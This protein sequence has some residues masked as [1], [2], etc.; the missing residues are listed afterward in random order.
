MDWKPE[1]EDRIRRYLLDDATPEERRQVEAQ[2]LEDDEYGELL[3]LIEDELID[4]YARGAL[5]ARES[6]LFARNYLVTPRRQQDLAVAREMTRYAAAATAGDST[7][8]EIDMTAE[9]QTIDGTVNQGRVSEAGQEHSWWQGLFVP[10]WKIAAYALLILGLGVGIWLGRSGSN[11]SELN[12]EQGLI[13]LNQ[14]YG[15][16]RPVEARITGFGHAYFPASSIQR[17]GNDR[18]P[19]EKEKEQVDYVALERAKLL[20]FGKQTDNASA[21][22]LHAFGTYF[23]TQREFDKAIEYLRQA[24]QLAPESAQLHSD[25][26]AA[27]LGKIDSE[28]GTPAGRRNEDVDECFA[29][30][31]QALTLAPNLPEALFNRALLNQHERLRREARADWEQ[32]LRQDSQSP[33]AKEA[34]AN[35]DQVEAELRNI[36]RRREQLHQDFMAALAARDDEGAL[37][38]FSLS[39]SFNGNSIVE[40]LLG[41]LLAARSAGQREVVEER[42]RALSHIGRL[43]EDK[44]GDRFTAELASFYRK[45]R[46][47]QFDLSAQARGLMAEAD[48]FYRKSENDRAI[49]R[50]EQAK[51]MFAQAGNTGEELFA[52]AWIGHCHHQRSDTTRNLQVFSALAPV[53]E[54]KKYRW[55]L[56][57]AL[58]G[59]ANGYNSSG[60]FSQ[61]IAASARCGQIAAELGDQTGVL[62]SQY[63]QGYFYYELGKHEENLRI[64]EQGKQLA[65][66]TAAEIRYAITFYNLRAWSL[67]AQSQHAAALA[68]QR[69]AVR[70]AEESKNLRLTAYAYIYQGLVYA[71]QK[72]F[73]EAVTSMNQGIAIGR[74]LPHE[75]TGQDFV[76]NGLRYLGNVYR[77]AGDFSAAQDC[78]DRSLK[79]Y[80]HSK[81]QSHFYVAAKGRLLTLIAQARDA[82]ARQ[83]LE[84]VLALYERHRASITEE[85][86]RN[87]FF[88]QEQN[89]YDVAVDFAYTRLHDPEQAYTYAEFS[90]SRSLL[91]LVLRGGVSVGES[92]T[93]DLVIKAHERPRGADQIRRQ[94]PES[95]Q[96]LEYAVLEDKVIVWIIS[97]GG[98]ER[99]A[100]GLSRERLNALIDEF[101]AQ[102]RKRPV[103][104]FQ[105]WR[106]PATVL[107]DQLIKPIEKWLDGSKQVCIIPDKALIHLPFGALVSRESRRLLIMDYALSYASSANIFLELTV[108]ARQKVLS[109]PE[110]LLAVGNPRFDKAGFPQ[111]EY[112]PDAEAEVT[113]IAAHY[114]TRELLLRA[115]A[116][117]SAVLRGLQRA[118]VAHFA[119][120][121]LPD[122]WSPMRS[123]VPLAAGGNDPPAGALQLYELYELCQ[124]PHLRLRLVVLAACQTRGEEVHAGEGAIGITRPFEAAGVPLIVASLWPV[125]DKSTAELMSAFHYARKKA[126]RTTV[127]ALRDTQLALLNSGGVYNHPY[128]WAAFIVQGGYSVY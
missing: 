68:W 83:E 108:R 52:R 47:E 120:H 104:D 55:M 23:L 25:L 32:Y 69:E 9:S 59:L 112:L 89:I 124:Q 19:G 121:Y 113:G 2:L 103:G 96:L 65:D 21:A 8:W 44:T 114:P 29:R 107:H 76:H 86:N 12:V 106:E 93:P 125:N 58:C 122:P 57:N 64:T 67:S 73:K 53:C 10:G 26:G 62:R 13:A 30:L 63:M 60:Q 46:P 33:W 75:T 37:R 88:D 18:G 115:Q 111:L 43:V 49:E 61:A 42:L 77:A 128:Y 15:R 72:R 17:G 85:S 119:L 16:Q 126:G 105:S 40:K 100:L 110:R 81:K 27:L 82:E 74:Q 6:G 71:R 36:N 5:P 1:E 38:S 41:D 91:D 109:E 92:E 78:F 127:A 4:D 99:E 117:K 51:E 80:E 28:R 116:T 24:L 50:Y 118:D 94:L 95:V 102:V 39:Y 11:P 101:L 7:G 123:R 98:V 56:S 34:R 22:S 87:S 3:L 70:M 54:E 31:N 14:A 79:F 35:L 84:R 90:R 66:E 45:A 48:R 20:L 97:R